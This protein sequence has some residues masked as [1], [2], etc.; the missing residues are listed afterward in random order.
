MT[1]H[2]IAEELVKRETTFSF[3]TKVL[4]LPAGCN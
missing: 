1:I 2:G 3:K 4:Q